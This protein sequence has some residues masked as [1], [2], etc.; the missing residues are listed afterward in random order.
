MSQ[1]IPNHYI[2]CMKMCVV[3]ANKNRNVH[4]LLH[5]F[6]NTIWIYLY[7]ILDVFLPQTQIQTLKT[8]IYYWFKDLLCTKG[9]KIKSLQTGLYENIF[10][11]KHLKSQ[12]EKQNTFTENGSW[13]VSQL[14]LKIPHVMFTKY[15]MNF[16][17]FTILFNLYQFVLC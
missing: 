17:T 10:F 8:W 1:N 16:W 15:D 2:Y 12:K 4:Q 3:S 13:I 14:I 9:Y 11:L 7:L 5:A 6:I